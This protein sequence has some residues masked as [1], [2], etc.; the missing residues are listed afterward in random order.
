MDNSSK[1]IRFFRKS[2]LLLACLTGVSLLIRA[3]VLAQLQ[4]NESSPGPIYLQNS[5]AWGDAERTA[6]YSQDQGSTLIPAAWLKALTGP[7]GQ[8]FLAGSLTRYGYLANPARTDGLPIGF[9]TTQFK[10]AS[11]VG[12]TC[13]ACHTREISL[14]TNHYRIDGG[15]A[16]SDFQQFLTDLVAAVGRVNSDDAFPAFADAVLGPKANAAQRKALRQSVK[17]WFDRENALAQKAYGR[18]DLWG[19]G[20]LDAVA[21]I[22]NRVAGLDVG[23]PPS[24]LLEDNIQLADAPTRYPFIWNATLQDKTQWP[25]FA[26]NG[27]NLFGLARNLGEVYGVFATF[28]PSSAPLSRPFSRGDFIKTNSANFVG[29]GKLENLVGKIPSPK[30][31]WRID[32]DLAKRGRLIFESASAMGGCAECHQLTNGKPRFLN[33]N[34]WATP[35]QDVGTDSREY[36]ILDREGRSGVLNGMQIPLSGDRIQATDKVLKMLKTSVVNAL[37]QGGVLNASKEVFKG[38]GANLDFRA[39]VPLLDGAFRTGKTVE[40]P[41]C[42]KTDKPYCYEARVLTGIWAAAPYLHNGSVPTLE[43]LLKPA[44]ERPVTFAVGPEY[45]PERAGLAITQPTSRY[46]RTTTGCEARD[47]GNSRCGHE[48]GTGL[49]AYDKKALLEYLKTL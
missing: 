39:L 47:S 46:A 4:G 2:F 40:D 33:G 48:Y 29:L 17:V 21:M 1:T 23:P 15:P 41:L 24:Y 35:V 27:D 10:G 25:G 43:D 12:M 30:W 5:P 13:A 9:T 31:P 16:L 11:Y 32:A 45:D 37:L 7:D 8:P 18:P 38:S 42:N 34:T 19:L 6:F 14:G 3:P 36:Q 26:D 22:L 28:H 20:R 44:A 49:A